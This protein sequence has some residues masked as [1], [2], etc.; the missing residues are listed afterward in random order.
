MIDLKTV[1]FR[2]E[3]GLVARQRLNARGQVKALDL[4]AS[5]G[6]IASRSHRVPTVVQVLPSTWCHR[7]SLAK[8][9]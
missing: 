1:R 9:L 6:Q 5:K 8:G 2:I 7:S 4:K 3:R